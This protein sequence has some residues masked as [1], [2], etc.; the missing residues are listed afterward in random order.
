MAAGEM[1]HVSGD[2][3]RILGRRPTS[4]AEFLAGK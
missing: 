4:L 2:V 3:E 1:G